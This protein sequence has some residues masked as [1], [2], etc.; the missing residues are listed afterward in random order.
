MPE[1]RDTS[2]VR[3]DELHSDA[4]G[5]ART[6]GEPLVAQSLSIANDDSPT[7]PVAISPESASVVGVRTRKCK[8][9]EA[10]PVTARSR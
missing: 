6:E 3:F 8:A 10:L 1:R 9:R 4:F 7:V 5:I 2:H